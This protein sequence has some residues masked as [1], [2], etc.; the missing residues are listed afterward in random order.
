MKNPL[1][2]NASLLVA[3]VTALAA[4]YWFAQTLNPKTVPGIN[5]EVKQTPAT[6]VPDFTLPDLEGTEVSLSRW[7]GKYILLNFWATWCAPC[8]EEIPLFNRLQ[9]RFGADGLQ[10]VGIA[11]D[12]ADAVMAFRVRQPLNYPVL[13]G[14]GNAMDIMRRYGNDHGS[15]PFSVLIGPQGLKFAQK[16]GAF[17]PQELDALL[18]TY[19]PLPAAAFDHD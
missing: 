17:T 4:G 16:L 5:T 1:L 18:Q 2:R 14:E 6:P 9:K 13:I 3:A 7:R 15:L 11:V 10:V 12:R 19:L 8:L